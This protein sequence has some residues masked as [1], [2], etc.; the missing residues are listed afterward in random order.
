MTRSREVHSLDRE[1]DGRFAQHSP[2][3]VAVGP[4]RPLA[5]RPA[6][7]I[8]HPAAKEQHRTNGI[9][10]ENQKSPNPRPEL[11][12]PTLD[13]RAPA[14]ASASIHSRKPSDRMRTPY[15]PRA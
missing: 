3:G 13:R 7:S 11:L 15:T 5:L 9:A 1:G 14:N 2:Q 6:R 10:L 8:K 12:P 4:C